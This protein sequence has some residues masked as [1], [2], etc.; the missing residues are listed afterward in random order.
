MSHSNQFRSDIGTTNR[1]IFKRDYSFGLGMRIWSQTNPEQWRAWKAAHTNQPMTMAAY[2]TPNPGLVVSEEGWADKIL[3][4][5]LPLTEVPVMEADSGEIALH[6]PPDAQFEATL[7]FAALKR[8]DFLID[9]KRGVVWLRPK[10]TQ[11]MPYW[12]NRLGAVFVPKDLQSDDLVAHVVI[13]SPAYEA[14][15][16]DND[17]L[18]KIGNLD[19]TKWRTDPNVLPLSH[20]WNSLAGTKL[21]LT[22][23][24]GNK[25]FETKAILRNILPPD[26][27]KNSN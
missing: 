4:G 16:R 11:P 23:K 2:Y 5:S 1:K 18:L 6:S 19:C 15:I 8:L 26:S 24:R 22:L 17:V 12:H 25:K 9:G 10:K 14:G 20:F 21:E 7:G 3:L 27:M 13:G